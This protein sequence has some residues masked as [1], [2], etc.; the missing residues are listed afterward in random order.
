M[1]L[2]AHTRTPSDKNMPLPT[3]FAL[4]VALRRVPGTIL[5]AFSYIFY[6]LAFML[7]AGWLGLRGSTAKKPD[8]AFAAVLPSNA[9]YLSL[10]INHFSFYIPSSCI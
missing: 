7:Q 1:Q 3:T 10:L 5:I 8:T 4:F 2:G 9:F 6:K